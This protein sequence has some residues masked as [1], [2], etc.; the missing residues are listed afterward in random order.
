M[1]RSVRP[2]LTGRASEASS[3]WPTKSG[4]DLI[5]IRSKGVNMTIDNSL[6]NP[7][8]C[9]VTHF[10]EVNTSKAPAGWHFDNFD[11]KREEAPVHT[12]LANGHQY[13][14]I[15][16]MEEIRSSF[17]NAKVFSNS[18]VTPMEPNPQFRWIPEMLDGHEHTAWRQLTGPFFSPAAIGAWEPRVRAILTEV[19]DAIVDRGSCEFVSEVALLFPNVIFM[20]IMGLPKEDAAQFQQWEVDIL[21]KEYTSTEGQQRQMDAMIAVMDY[22]SVLIKERRDQPQDDMLSA[23]LTWEID[24]API[25]DQD[26]LDFCLLMFMAGLDTVA[27]QLTYSFWHLATHDDDRQRLLDDPAI[28]PV[29]VEEFLRYYS[30]VTPGRKVMS[31]TEIAGCP[32]KAGQMVYLP[33]VAANRDPREFDD[34]DKVI[35]DRESNR[36]VAFGVGPHRCLG[37]NLA[38][39]ELNIAMEMWHERIPNYRLVAGQELSEHGGQIG[40]DSLK[41]EW[42]V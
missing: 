28:M 4:Y 9:P 5:Q 2:G 16:R 36:H 7:T 17:Q 20:E 32:V 31:D 18:A 3:H 1:L 40:I 8:G 26:L 19:I 25:P 41:L 29:A 38:R 15:T 35:I 39:Q 34:A 11:V 37:S 30:F 24:G 23:A 33:L 6:E 21:H 27:A 14:L 12:G 22:F 10:T 13:F 42:D